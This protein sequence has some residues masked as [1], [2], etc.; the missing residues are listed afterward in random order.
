[1]TWVRLPDED[2]H[3]VEVAALPPD[4]FGVYIRLLMYSNQQRLGGAIPLSRLRALALSPGRARRLAAVGW[5][6]ESAA[7]VQLVRYLD[8]QPTTEASAERSA[9]R[10]SAGR[11][12]GFRSGEVR[13][14]AAGI[15]AKREASASSNREASASSTAEPRPVPSRPGSEI[16][17]ATS[18]EPVT[19][20]RAGASERASEA[21][22]IEAREH[23]IETPVARPPTPRGTRM[24]QDA[25][26]LPDGPTEPG[27][28]EREAAPPRRRGNRAS[29]PEPVPDGAT[30]SQ[31]A[32]VQ[33]PTTLAL[34]PEQIT[35]LAL[36]TGATAGQLRQIAARLVASWL[37]GPRRLAPER[38][39]AYLVHAVSGE[40]GR[41]ERPVAEPEP[42]G[43]EE[44]AARERRRVERDEAY[45]REAMRLVRERLARP[46]G[47]APPN[48]LFRPYTPEQLADLDRVFARPPNGGAK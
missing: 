33:C 6:T 15:E 35:V 7:G 12:G 24:P 16:L 25:P 19:S 42:P 18:P 38:W 40:W 21:R 5:L 10:A 45:E 8:L 39:G 26:T 11:T 34:T 4:A 44:L 43:P 13:R 32:P 29:G 31:G 28:D 17:P 46:I 9:A 3:G 36:G 48:P 41:G 30:P 20:A 14:A 23:E 22:G 1:M 27:P 2:A 47:T 37:G